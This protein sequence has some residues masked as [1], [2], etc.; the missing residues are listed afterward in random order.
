[1]VSSLNISNSGARSSISGESV[2]KGN[3]C[4]LVFDDLRSSVL[5]NLRALNNGKVRLDEFSLVLSDL[6]S[7]VGDFTE[8]SK[9][10]GNSGISVV[11]KV[12][13]DLS[14]SLGGN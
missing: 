12:S 14:D 4:I 5:L 11:L 3:S 9:N 8:L 7:S 6:S 10:L 2:G 13:V 1:M